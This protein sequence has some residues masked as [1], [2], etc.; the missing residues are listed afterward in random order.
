[1]SLQDKFIRYCRYSRRLWG[2]EDVDYSYPVYSR[3]QKFEDLDCPF[4]YIL[5]LS[6]TIGI[7]RKKAYTIAYEYDLYTQEC[8]PINYNIVSV[9]AVFIYRMTDLSKEEVC[10][11]AYINTHDFDEMQRKIQGDMKDLCD[12]FNR[13]WENRF[14]ADSEGEE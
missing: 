9:A 2:C 1:M 6:Y 3:I 12:A 14:Q 4:K 11:L 7:S 8:A 5:F 13:E 10:E